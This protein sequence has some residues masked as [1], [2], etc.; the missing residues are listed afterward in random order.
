MS[1]CAFPLEFSH[2]T[3][4]KLTCGN[5]ETWIF[6]VLTLPS[7]RRCSQSNHCSARSWH[8]CPGRWW[9][10]WFRMQGI[11]QWVMCAKFRCLFSLRGAVSM[12]L[13]NT[14][15]FFI[16]FP[17]MFL[18]NSETTSGYYKNCGEWTKLFYEVSDQ[19]AFL[20]R[21]NQTF[22]M[23]Q[24][25]LHQHWSVCGGDTSWGHRAARSSC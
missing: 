21:R 14:E 11:R 20:L 3:T 2:T 4:G 25:R 1:C 10:I 5:P 23:A 16:D 8:T 12:G 13:Y 6:V 17:L 19:K 18:L 15:R 24:Q 22:C 7:F 9:E